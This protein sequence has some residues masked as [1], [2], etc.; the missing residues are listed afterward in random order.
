MNIYEQVFDLDDAG[1][2]R[3]CNSVQGPEV[4]HDKSKR[5]KD[6]SMSYTTALKENVLPRNW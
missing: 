3:R 5:G 6:P 1:P 2:S 4:E